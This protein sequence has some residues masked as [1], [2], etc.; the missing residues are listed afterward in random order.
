MANESAG[1]KWAVY[2]ANVQQYRVLAAT[3]QSFLVYWVDFLHTGR[4]SKLFDDFDCYSRL[5]AYPIYMV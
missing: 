1:T 2:E 4:G 5:I 3:V